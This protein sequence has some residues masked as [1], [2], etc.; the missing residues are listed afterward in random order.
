MIDT[1]PTE[2]LT[3]VWTKSAVARWDTKRTLD[4]R[5][6]ISSYPVSITSPWFR[7]DMNR[8][9]GPSWIVVNGEGALV[10]RS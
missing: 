8:H 10:A 5:H 7:D 2:T 6:T 9:F 1:H 3:V 4:P